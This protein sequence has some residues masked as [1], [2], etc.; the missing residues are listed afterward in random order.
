MAPKLLFNQGPSEPCGATETD[1]VG[2]RRSEFQ[3]DGPRNVSAAEL[4]RSSAIPLLVQV[5]PF[6]GTDFSRRAFPIFSTVCL[7]LAAANSYD[8]QRLADHF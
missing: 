1:G 8:L 4:L 6:T 2:R 5:Q 3:T 7:E